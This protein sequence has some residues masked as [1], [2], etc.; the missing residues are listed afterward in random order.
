RVVLASAGDLPPVV[1]TVR[2]IEGEKR[3]RIPRR[4]RHASSPGFLRRA[5]EEK[6]WQTKSRE[7]PEATDDSHTE[8]PF[9]Y[10]DP[11][12]PT[13]GCLAAVPGLAT[14]LPNLSAAEW[15]CFTPPASAAS[16]ATGLRF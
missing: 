2:L 4:E 3:D 9:R 14:V 1:D 10:D 5:N 7:E 15:A 12:V 13:A 8:V 6:R 16:S 11:M